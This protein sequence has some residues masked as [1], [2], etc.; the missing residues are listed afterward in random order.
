M[1]VAIDGPAAAGKSTVAKLIAN[2][3]HYIYIDTGAMYRA[4]TLKAHLKDVDVHNEQALEQLLEEC[5]IVLEKEQDAQR[6]WLDGEEVT[7]TIRNPEINKDVSFVAAHKKVRELM[8]NRQQKLAERHNVVMDGRD[9]GTHVLPKADVKVFLRASVKERAQR[10]YKEQ[11]TKGI[12]TPLSELE[13]EI[14]LRDKRDSE[15]ETAPLTKADDAYE[16]DTTSL[17]IEEVADRILSL[18]KEAS[19][20]DTL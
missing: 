5:E 12:Q 15:R 1:Q 9:I 18:I 6:V 4:L 17:T 8:V 7:Q 14:S 3:L 19:L 13:E 16:L 10:R 2:R 11:L 20:H